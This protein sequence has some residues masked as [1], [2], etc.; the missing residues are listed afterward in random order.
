M[1][2]AVMSLVRGLATLPIVFALAGPGESSTGPPIQQAVPQEFVARVNQYDETHRRVAAALGPPEICSDPEEL[3][4][5]ER[6]FAR[7]IHQRRPNAREGDIFTPDAARYFQALIAEV[8]WEQGLD[9]VTELADA[10]AWDTEAAVLQV[11][12]QMPW[13]AGPMMWAS[14]HARLP[15]LPLE[16][17]YRFVGRDLVLVDILGNVIVDVLREA[18]PTSPLPTSE[19]SES[20]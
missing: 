1:I 9:V 3:L 13:K 8:T 11:N 19:S 12:A 14:I 10:Q 2:E 7:A 15:E 6:A 18:L 16:L 20:G 4:R 17:E 5:H